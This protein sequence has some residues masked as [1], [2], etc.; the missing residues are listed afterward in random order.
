MQCN[1]S[2]TRSYQ[3]KI[4]LSAYFKLNLGL[5]WYFLGGGGWGWVVLVETK[6]NLAQF[7]WNCQLELSLAISL[8]RSLEL[9]KFE[10]TKCL[11]FFWFSV[12]W[13][14]YG[15]IQ[16]FY[17]DCWKWIF[18]TKNGPFLTQK[19][20]L[21]FPKLLS[22]AWQQKLCQYLEYHPFL[23]IVSNLKT[24]IPLFL[25]H[26]VFVFKA[27]LL[28]ALSPFNSVHSKHY[29]ILQVSISQ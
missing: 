23:T 3:I 16:V 15:P 25:R 20:N 22:S 13:F 24:L 19:W 8:L 21:R 10:N 7:Q 5:V 18:L 2:Q 1:L 6:A 26:P 4:W 14:R 29:P 27:G 28:F 9:Y 11:Y 12:N 17:S